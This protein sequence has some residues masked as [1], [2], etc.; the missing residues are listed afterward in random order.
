LDLS[1]APDGPDSNLRDPFLAAL[2]ERTRALRLRRGLTRKALAKAAEVSE[3]HLANVEM[4][5]D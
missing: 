3:R 5:V 1:A 4:G 2:G